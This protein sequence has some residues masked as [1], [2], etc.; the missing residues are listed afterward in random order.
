MWFGD[1]WNSWKLSTSQTT[2]KNK[3]YYP[4]RKSTKTFH[5]IYIAFTWD[6]SDTFIGYWNK[7]IK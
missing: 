7:N 6:I 4:K 3:E 2:D 1:V 5:F